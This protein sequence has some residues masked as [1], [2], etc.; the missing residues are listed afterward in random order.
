MVAGG[1]GGGGGTI[2]GSVD[3]TGLDTGEVPPGG[4]LL[5]LSVGY[6]PENVVQ[7]SDF[8]GRLS[9]ICYD[10]VPFIT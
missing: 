2:F 10:T 6:F 3:T 9:T 8:F 7:S 4:A 1:G 5:A